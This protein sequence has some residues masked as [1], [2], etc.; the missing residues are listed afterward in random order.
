MYEYNGFINVSI[1]PES[2]EING[3]PDP[4]GVLCQWTVRGYV[5]REPGAEEW[6]D[7]DGALA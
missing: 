7:N 1:D 6:L 2:G 4:A 3:P 5:P